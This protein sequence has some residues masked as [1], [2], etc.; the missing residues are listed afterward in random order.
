MAIAK[1]TAM[2]VEKATRPGL[3]NDGGGLYLRVARGGSKGWIFRY[4][5]G[6]RT[7]DMGLG[8][9]DT[10]NLKQA[11][12]RARQCREL[13]YD[14]IDPIES[15]RARQREAQ[16]EAARVMTFRQCAE[17]YIAAHEASWSS[18]KHAAQWPSTMTRFVY[19][20]FGELS[21]QA[22][23]TG[24]VLKAIEPIWT[25][26]TETASR[27]RGRIEAVLDWAAARGY[28]QGDNPARW[29]GHLEKFRPKS[30]R[31]RRSARWPC[32]LRRAPRHRVPS[33]SNPRSWRGAG[34]RA[35]S[36][37]RDPAELERHLI[38]RRK[39]L[40]SF[41]GGGSMLP[42]IAT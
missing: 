25:A 6:G 21:V 23:D 7:R 3:Y 11:R 37:T 13:C 24:L 31:R 34:G 4:A 17:A 10:F 36:S 29:R 22:I 38:E 20:I 19:P 8:S 14:G 41:D 12:D 1:L 5:L 40:R 16:L 30:R 42:T 9:V 18:P 27:V 39:S 26:K 35:R 33:R 15:R 28:R 32:G 2:Q